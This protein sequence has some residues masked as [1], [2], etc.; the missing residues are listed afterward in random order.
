MKNKSQNINVGSSSILMIFV[1]LCLICFASLSLVSATSDYK[2]SKKFAEKTTAYYDACN[3]AESSISSIDASLKASAVLLTEDEYFT[4][5]G[6]FISFYVPINELQS[7]YISLSPQYPANK[8][9]PCYLLT[10]Y[11]VITLKPLETENTLNF[12]TP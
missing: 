2:L 3:M 8:Y 10:N 12:F 1:V 6:T 5:V 7:L 9:E 11:E 4:K